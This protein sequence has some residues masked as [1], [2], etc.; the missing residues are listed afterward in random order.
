M[1]STRTLLS[2]R[3][4]RNVRHAKQFNTSRMTSKKSVSFFSD[5]NSIANKQICCCYVDK[6]NTIK[7]MNYFRTTCI[8]CITFIKMADK[9]WETIFH[10]FISISTNETSCCPGEFHANQACK[11]QSRQWRRFNKIR[12]SRCQNE[13][14]KRGSNARHGGHF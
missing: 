4:A 14:I 9:R 10:K 6:K 12:F 13:F 5:G 7:L 8:V 1:A 2:S 3:M 11:S